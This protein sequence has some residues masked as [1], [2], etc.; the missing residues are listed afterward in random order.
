MIERNQR[1]SY[2]SFKIYNC[3]KHYQPVEK[4]KIVNLIKEI[5]TKDSRLVFAY[6]YG[7]SVTHPN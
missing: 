5:L 4:D 1:F 3:K 2:Y 6:V 7:S